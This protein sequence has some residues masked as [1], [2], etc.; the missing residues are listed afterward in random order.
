MA[1]VSVVSV[2][3]RQGRFAPVNGERKT[4]NMQDISNAPATPPTRNLEGRELAD[5][6]LN[7]K[8][9][10]LFPRPPRQQQAIRRQWKQRKTMTSPC[11]R[12]PILRQESWFRH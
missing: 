6:V 9:P 8:Q 11:R 1:V 12:H 5:G 4:A 2:L 10:R 3:E 7:K